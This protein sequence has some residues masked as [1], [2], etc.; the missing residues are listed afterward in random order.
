MSAAILGQR[1]QVFNLF[2]LYVAAEFSHV[3][4]LL[5]P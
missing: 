5:E 2:V 1:S 4:M 3:G